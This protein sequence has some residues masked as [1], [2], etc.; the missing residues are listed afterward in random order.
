MLLSYACLWV[1]SLTL[2]LGLF[3][4]AI[5]N[6]GLSCSYITNT[7]IH[8]NCSPG[9]INWWTE[10]PLACSVLGGKKK[11][12]QRMSATGQVVPWL[13]PS[14]YEK[15][16][17]VRA[18]IMSCWPFQNWGSQTHLFHLQKTMKTR[19][20][21]IH[22]DKETVTFSASPSLNKAVITQHYLS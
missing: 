21:K 17:N 4:R 14:A 10:Q 5:G 22:R 16:T 19:N 7:S 20:T 12:S 13:P 1:H 15:L 3:F 6:T 8:P 2:E 18:S 11:Q 9:I